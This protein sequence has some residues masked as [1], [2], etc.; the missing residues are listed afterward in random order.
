MKK[1]EDVEM[2]FEDNARTCDD[3]IAKEIMLISNAKGYRCPFYRRYR[4]F[5]QE[6]ILEENKV[7]VNHEARYSQEF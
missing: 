2:V 5:S 4:H 1:T 7:T 3:A 6:W